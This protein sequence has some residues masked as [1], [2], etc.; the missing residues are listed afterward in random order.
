MENIRDFVKSDKNDYYNKVIEIV[1]YIQMISNTE[2]AIFGGFVRDLI[3]DKIPK[4]V[5]IWFKYRR[6]ITNEIFR[7]NFLEMV[8]MLDNKYST[9][10]N[11]SETDYNTYSLII[12]GIRFDFCCNTFNNKSFNELADFSVNNLY[13]LTDGVLQVRVP[14]EYNVEQIISH[15]RQRKLLYII[16]SEVVQSDS[17][18]ND[19]NQLYWQNVE[20]KLLKMTGYGYN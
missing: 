9:I 8:I 1:K 17:Y 15:I 20:K 16:N 10:C 13:M 5:D 19:S 6:T 7:A 4:D 2:I 3:N 14:C 18:W 12:E 11:D